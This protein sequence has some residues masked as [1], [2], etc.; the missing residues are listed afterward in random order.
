MANPKKP[1]NPDRARPEKDGGTAV[2]TETRPKTK[3]PSLYKVL[4]HN[5]DYTTKEF[6]VSVLMSVFG[7]S[8]NE[9]NAIMMHVHATGIGVA[10]VFTYEVAETKA[11]KTMALAREFEYPLRVTVEKE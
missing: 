7:H 10:G 8:E 11:E 6:V 4:F 3:R 9:A 1:A 5:D 2:A